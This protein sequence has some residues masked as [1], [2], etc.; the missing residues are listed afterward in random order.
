MRKAARLPILNSE[1][2]FWESL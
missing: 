2:N 1:S